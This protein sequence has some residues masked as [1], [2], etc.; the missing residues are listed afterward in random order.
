M[1]L[2]KWPPTVRSVRAAYEKIGLMPVAR[3]FLLTRPNGKGKRRYVGCCP[4][5]ALALAHLGRPRFAHR[6]PGESVM[7]MLEGL[8][9][10]SHFEMAAFM[11]GVDGFQSDHALVIYRGEDASYR[12]GRAVARALKILR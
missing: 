6:W 3:K 10:A 4:M 8:Y 1:T 2:R 5:T 11:N 12:A 9:D 7:H